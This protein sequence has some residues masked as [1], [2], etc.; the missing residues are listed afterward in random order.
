[1]LNVTDLQN[2]LA[3]SN[4]TVTTTG[5]GV[6]AGDIKSDA[7]FA[8]SNSNK[9]ALDAYQ[10][11]HI[12]MPVSIAGQGGLTIT[13]ND[14]GKNGYFGFGAKGNITFAN[15]SSALSINGAGYMLAGNIATLASDIATNPSGSYALANNYDAS[16]DGTYSSSPIATTFGGN[17]NGLG[18]TISNL[19][20]DDSTSGD[21][22]GFFSS[23]QSAGFVTGIR[24][25]KFSIKASTNGAGIG[26][27]AGVSSGKVANAYVNGSL[28]ASSDRAGA[29]RGGLIGISNGNVIRS[30]SSVSILSG[31]NNV[32]GGLVGGNEGNIAESYAVATISANTNVYVGGAMGANEGSVTQSYAMGR[33]TGSG[34]QYAGGFVGVNGI[35][36]TQSYS[37]TALKNTGHH[38][39][40]AGGLI[41]LDNLSS[42]S[43]KSDYWDRTTSKIRGRKRGA[44][45]PKKDPGITGLTTDQL[46]SAL[47]TG[48]DPKVWAED[49]NINNGYPYL[50]DNPPQK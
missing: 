21:N 39:P 45:S 40:D 46:Q 9:L 1:M 6:Q 35:G 3:S 11:V 12:E 23:I 47:P 33:I 29:G 41:G 14:G 7:P 2:L 19:T 10:S 27:L 36:I 4:V 5:S 50:I 49:K 18:N 43:D 22:V 13:T 44:G 24:L 38:N 20:I 48:F 37:T 15:L 25:S 8:W 26:G 30:G 17:F 34:E 42:G 32:V 28:D 16:G 31:S